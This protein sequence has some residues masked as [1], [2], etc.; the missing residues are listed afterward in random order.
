MAVLVSAL[1]RD[2]SKA[3]GPMRSGR[4]RRMVMR[5]A[6]VVVLALT[7]VVRQVLVDQRMRHR[8]ARQG[9]RSNEQD[10]GRTARGRERHR[11]AGYPVGLPAHRLA[12]AHLENPAETPVY[13]FVL[14][15]LSALLFG[16]STPA[17]K[18]LLGLLYL[19]AAAGMAPIA[20]LEQ[21]RGARMVFDRT[22]ALRLAGADSLQ[23]GRLLGAPRSRLPVLAPLRPHTLLVGASSS[24]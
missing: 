23:R 17:S 10:P 12:A 18:W 16:A 2:Q 8:P 14:A 4:V 11:T 5:L 7:V 20:V 1:V 6:P 19:G 3:F 22:N 13:G 21:R 9:Q 15:L 24:R